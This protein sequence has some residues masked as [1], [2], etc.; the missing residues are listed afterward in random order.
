MSGYFL[1]QGQGEV[2]D[3]GVISMRLL[4][5]KAETRG[6]FA[7]AEFRGA[8]G[9]WTV[10]HVHRGLEE[11]FYVLEGTF[12]FT[13]RDRDVEAKQGAFVMVPRGTPHVISAGPGGGALLT[14]WAPGGLEEMFLELGRLPADSIT[15]PEVRAEIAN[16]HD[17]VPV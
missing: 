10:P 14:L 5:S 6:A 3:L 15:N 16:R 13:Y 11:S 12:T 2:A 17:S 1:D 9:Q 4:V 8:E 7:A